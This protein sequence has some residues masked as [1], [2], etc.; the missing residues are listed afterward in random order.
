MTPPV[1]SLKNLYSCQLASSPFASMDCGD[2]NYVIH[3]VKK[4]GILTSALSFAFLSVL[5]LSLAIL[6]ITVFSKRETMITSTSTMK[7]WLSFSCYKR[8][9]LISW[10]VQ[11]TAGWKR[12]QD[13]SFFCVITQNIPLKQSIPFRSELLIFCSHISWIFSSMNPLIFRWERGQLRIFLGLSESSSTRNIKVNMN[14]NTN[15][16]M[17]RGFHFYAAFFLAGAPTSAQSS[18]KL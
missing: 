4:L 7:I 8:S 2:S 12:R 17:K 16:N 13:F 10:L 9:S 6:S 3:K 11:T 1:K 18:E 5:Q 15:M 14:M